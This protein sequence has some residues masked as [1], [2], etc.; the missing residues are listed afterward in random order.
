MPFR[1]ALALIALYLV[2]VPA[3][4]QNAPA[5]QPI[6]ADV[7]RVG[8]PARLRARPSAVADLPIGGSSLGAGGGSSLRAGS[9]PWGQGETV[10]RSPW[11]A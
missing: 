5:T 11:P 9:H 6:A 4:T 7:T 1:F 3:R 10:P 8:C 2:A